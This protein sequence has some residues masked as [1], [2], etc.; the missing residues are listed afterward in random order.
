MNSPIL[1]FHSKHPDLDL[2]C[3]TF[4]AQ[5]K[6]KCNKNL[7]IMTGGKRWYSK[8]CFQVIQSASS[9]HHARLAFFEGVETTSKRRRTKDSSESSLLTAGD[10]SYLV[11]DS[12]IRLRNPVTEVG[13]WNPIISETV[14]VHPSVLFFLNHQQWWRVAPLMVDVC[15]TPNASWDEKHKTQPFPFECG[16]FSPNVGKYPYV[17]HLG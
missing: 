2:F 7:P 4:C 14:S 8:L 10:G 15:N 9:L 6:L 17:E 3:N 13:S 5:K 12:E 11:D 1:A 16:H